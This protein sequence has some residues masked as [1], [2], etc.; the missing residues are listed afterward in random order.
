MSEHEIDRSANPGHALGQLARALTT[1]QEHDDPEV[2]AHRDADRSVGERVRGHAVRRSVCARAGT[3]G[4]LLVVAWL[5][6][7]GHADHARA[8]LDHIGPHFSRLRFYPVPDP[9]PLTPSAVVHVQKV[10]EILEDAHHSPAFATMRETIQ[11]WH[12]LCDRSCSSSSRRS[13]APPRC[14]EEH[15][16]RQRAEF[17]QRFRPAMA[18]LGWTT[19]QHWLLV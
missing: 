15:V 18:G 8:V 19:S 3:P 13:M 12:P 11:V 4:A 10:R 5:V 7:D 9:V 16:A 14:C 6:E 17:Q 2:R 1:S